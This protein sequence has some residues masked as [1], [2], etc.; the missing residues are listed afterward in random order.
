MKIAFCMP[1]HSHAK[2]GFVQC[3]GRLCDWTYRARF[4]DQNGVASRIETE[5]IVIGSSN[6][7]HSRNAIAQE[8]LDWGADWLFWLDADQTFPPDALGRLLARQVPMIG[9]NYRCR[10]PDQRLSTASAVRGGR[11][12][13]IFPEGEGI[14]E[15]SHLGLG[16]FL[17]RADVMRT[18]GSPWFRFGET[19]EGGVEGEDVHFF[20]K[21]KAAGFTPYVDHA[22][23]RQI[24]HVADIELMF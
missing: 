6:V 3:F 9:C 22:L 5:T 20:R 23:S 1:I 11:E 15:V 13:A 21:A 4:Q 24:G 12:V 18:V 14:E 16:V 8:A 2:P 7:A 10:V 19:P 17:V